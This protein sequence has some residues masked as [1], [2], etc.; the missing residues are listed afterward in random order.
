M[1][2]CGSPITHQQHH[3]ISRFPQ[4]RHS[5]HLTPW[6][7][8][9][10]IYSSERR[11]PPPPFFSSFQHSRFIHTP[12]PTRTRTRTPTPTPTPTHKHTHTHT[13][14][15][16]PT[17][18]S[19]ASLLSLYK[20]NHKSIITFFTTSKARR[21]SIKITPHISFHIQKPGPS[22]P[23]SLPP[24]PPPKATRTSPPSLPPS[25]PPSSHTPT[26]PPAQATTSTHPSL[27]PSLPPSPF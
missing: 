9:P 16:T 13:H 8:F 12:T 3:L 27:P 26:S 22:L 20:T 24:S 25:L 2:A 7:R 21:K 14:T 1:P 18:L 15:H 19:P 11:L 17:P 23:P 10:S 5:I 6:P 4:Q